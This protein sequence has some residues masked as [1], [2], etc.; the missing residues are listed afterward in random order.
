LGSARCGVERIKLWYGVEELTVTVS[1]CSSSDHN[2][3]QFVLEDGWPLVRLD[4]SGSPRILGA[5]YGE[6]NEVG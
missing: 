4:G 1:R 3:R 6:L 2:R 5:T